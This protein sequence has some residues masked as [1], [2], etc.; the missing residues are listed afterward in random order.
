LIK[1]G[2]EFL[3]M[4]IF[5][6]AVLAVIFMSLSGVANAQVKDKAFK[7]WTV[8]TADL[9]G[10]KSCYIAS[11]P[12]SKTGNYKKRDEPYMLVTKIGDGIFEVSVSSGFD[13]KAN[14]DVKAD[15]QGDKYN[16]FT[17]GDLAWAKDSK[18]DA[19]IVAA[20]KKKSNVN[21]RGTSLKGSYAVDKY[22]LS[23]FGDAYNRMNTLCE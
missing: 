7:N 14:S 9:K 4:K 12:T 2:L 13:Y 18:Q 5:I 19:K 11:F 20:M 21:I 10:K 1:I 8:Y 23:G 3:G 22:S 15:V 16:M 17:K 6:S